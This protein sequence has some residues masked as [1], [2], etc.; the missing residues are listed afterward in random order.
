MILDSPNLFENEFA[1][2]ADY[3]NRDVTLTAH[4]DKSI[5]QACANDSKLPKSLAYDS[6]V[7]AH[8]DTPNKLIGFSGYQFRHMMNNI[9]SLPSAN[10]LEVGTYMGS[11]LVSAVLGNEGTLSSVHAIDNFSEFSEST[12][13]RAS[14]LQNIERFLPNA[15][16]QFYEEDCFQFDVRKLPKIDVFF[17]DGEHSE[18]SQRN[19]FVHF[20]P[21]F[22]DTF[23]AVIDDWEQE[24]VRR[25]TRSA[26]EDL[27]FDIVSS[28]AIIPGK[29]PTPFETPSLQWWNGTHIAV[30]RKRVSGV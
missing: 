21:A 15:D 13:P 10:Y 3:N 18:E 14:F 1:S 8:I 24:P 28:R 7:E 22:A 19:A 2:M 6:V 23:I 20:Y 27:G 30:L 4:V 11:T 12:N 5:Q 16:I 17:Y 29:R 25:G 9:C 26:W